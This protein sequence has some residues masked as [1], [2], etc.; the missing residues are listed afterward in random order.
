MPVERYLSFKLDLCWS[1]HPKM[2][3]LRF[4]SLATRLLS[5]LS[6]R[7]SIATRRKRSCTGSSAAAWL[8]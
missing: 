2:S 7:A 4:N 8:P 1:G 3:L 5:P 6:C